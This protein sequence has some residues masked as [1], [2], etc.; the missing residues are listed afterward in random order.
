MPD[1][2]ARRRYPA[3]LRER[4]VRMALDRI[5]QSGDRSAAINLVAGELEVGPQSLRRWVGQ[6][7]LARQSRARRMTVA[8]AR[9]LFPEP[10]QLPRIQDSSV[11]VKAV[12]AAGTVTIVAGMVLLVIA[13]QTEIIEET[14]IGV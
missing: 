11:P 9:A 14:P 2:P 1:S 4:A 3:E 10:V 6:A 13:P 8:A 12:L 5:E 7:E